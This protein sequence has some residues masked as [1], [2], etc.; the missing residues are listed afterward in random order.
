MKSKAPKAT[1]AATRKPKAKRNAIN[2]AT[3]VE[4]IDFPHTRKDHGKWLVTGA[5]P[6][7]EPRFSF[8]RLTFYATKLRELGMS[9]T[10]IACMFSDLYWD[11][12]SEFVLNKTYDHYPE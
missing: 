4:G 7:N 9:D 8:Q 2:V 11:A 10:D 1:K 3:L 6:R 12:F 5:A